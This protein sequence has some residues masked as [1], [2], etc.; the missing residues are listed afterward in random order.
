MTHIGLHPQEK[1]EFKDNELV[2]YCFK[3]TR[4]DIEQDYLKSGRSMILEKIK[5]E[6]KSGGCNC[7]EKNPKGR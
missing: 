1:I 2:C 5:L 6:K 4:Q 7:A 3:Y